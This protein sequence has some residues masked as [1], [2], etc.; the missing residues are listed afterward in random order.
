[1]ST[2]AVEPGVPR[3][4]EDPAAT[5]AEPGG[6]RRPVVLA[7]ALVALALGLATGL[8]LAGGILRPAVA[9]E[10]SAD[11]GFARDMQV[12]HA[13]AVEMSVLVRDRT[14][15]PDVRTLALD[16]L[17]TQQQQQ[18]QMFGW[19]ATWG[20]PQASAQEPMAWMADHHDEASVGTMPGLATPEQ[21]D[22][23]ADAT[24]VEAE[25]IYLALMIPHHQGG[26]DMARAALERVEQPQVRR[27]A[28]A[29]VRAQQ[30]EITVLE[31][32]LAERGGAPDGL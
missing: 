32:M 9:A 15:D 6:V 22:R 31:R 25:R 3:D 17:L 27:F 11:A 19:L 23:L 21:M 7:L 30:A 12:H 28:E 5:A 2:E 14:D 1:M 29:V 24:G 10:G 26:V 20:L 18:G 8:L 4:G 16:I 13:Q